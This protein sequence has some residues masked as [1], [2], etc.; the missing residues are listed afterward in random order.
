MRHRGRIPNTELNRIALDQYCLRLKIDARKQGLS[1]D[2]AIDTARDYLAKRATW[3]DIESFPWKSR[4]KIKL[5][6][7]KALGEALVFTEREWWYLK[8]E[9]GGVPIIPIDKGKDALVREWIQA[10][11]N[12]SAKKRSN[13]LKAERAAVR[14]VLETEVRELLKQ[15]LSYTDIAERFDADHIEHPSARGI[16]IWTERQVFAFNPD[17]KNP[18]HK[19]KYQAE[20]KG[21]KRQAMTGRERKAANIEKARDMIFAMYLE[22]YSTRSISSILNK[23]KIPSRMGRKWH[24]MS[25]QRELGRDNR[26]QQKCPLSLTADT[27]YEPVRERDAK[28]SQAA[29]VETRQEEYIQEEVA[30]EQSRLEWSTPTLIEMPYTNALRQLYRERV[31]EAA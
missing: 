3:Y 11:R 21:A 23:R 19:R 15:G 13:K 29:A 28:L 9:R 5:L 31:A 17:R 2:H 20:R 30:K 16:H 8:S 12:K 27:R 7:A 1:P 18:E 4:D 14:K 6:S 10:A 26:R 22:G 25:V 24:Q